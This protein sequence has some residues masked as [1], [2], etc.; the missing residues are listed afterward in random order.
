MPIQISSASGYS[1]GSDN[2]SG[3]FSSNITVS[4][5]PFTPSSISGLKV[6]LDA[7]DA[8]TINAG[9]PADGDPITT[10]TDKSANAFSFAQASVPLKPTYK[11]A[12]QNGLGIA[13]GA[14]S[15]IGANIGADLTEFS[16]FIVVNVTTFRQFDC[17]L[18]SNTQGAG[19]GTIELGLTSQFD[20]YKSGTGSQMNTG[21]GTAPTATWMIINVTYSQSTPAGVFYIN[22]VSKNTTVSPGMFLSGANCNLF[23]DGAAGFTAF[24]GDIGSVIIYNSVLSL[25]DRTNVY[26]YLKTRWGL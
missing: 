5:A 13:R 22:N 25:T 16:V 3:S 19:Q 9:S 8:S 24:R 6:W 11:A 26:N 21:L 12:I 20:F 18:G 17:I 23:D 7:G 10:W 14:A 2:N 1:Q 15:L 4:A